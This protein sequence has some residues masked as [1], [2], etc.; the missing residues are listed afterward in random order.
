MSILKNKRN[1]T[2]PQ[3]GIYKHIP[4]R[5]GIVNLR[6]SCDTVLRGK[7]VSPL[8][9]TPLLDILKHF[10]TPVLF[11]K[12][13]CHITTM[14]QQMTDYIIAMLVVNTQRANKSPSPH[15]F[16]LPTKI[17]EPFLFLKQ[18][19][20]II[21]SN[22]IATAQIAISLMVRCMVRCAS[23]SAGTRPVRVGNVTK[24]FPPFTVISKILRPTFHRNIIITQGQ[25]RVKCCALRIR[26]LVS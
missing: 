1:N 4:L 20:I 6:N 10:G 13:K 19:I 26:C 24:V 3:H 22:I 12:S 17:T 15:S 2:S 8:E 5:C 23:G 14:A 7:P 11:N 16:G 18:T 21:Q 9:E 25:S